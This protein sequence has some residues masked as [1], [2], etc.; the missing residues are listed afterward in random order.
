V[1]V[2]NSYELGNIKNF[3]RKKIFDEVQNDAMN[4]SMYCSNNLKPTEK[5]INV[6]E[7]LKTEKTNF[8]EDSLLTKHFNLFIQSEFENDKSDNK[9]K[10]YVS[11]NITDEDKRDYNIRRERFYLK[12][13]GLKKEVENTKNRL[14]DIQLQ[15]RV[16]SPL[17]NR[18]LNNKIKI[19]HNGPKNRIR[20][21][22]LSVSL[23]FGRSETQKFIPIKLKEKH[24]NQKN[25]YSKLDT[26]EN[27]NEDIG[28]INNTC[29]NQTP[30]KLIN[31]N[32]VRK[33]NGIEEQTREDFYINKDKKNDK[34]S[35]YKEVK[36]F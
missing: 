19:I 17:Q 29:P 18:I 4:V 5:S 21:V 12:I 6:L 34:F 7:K 20:P 13:K 11:K 9:S 24:S 25:N 22:D 31:E 8:Y 35:I 36:I 16:L 3:N 26:F 28:M 30:I 27:C 14:N 2:N 1:N 32:S 15:G 23:G 33:T 10:G